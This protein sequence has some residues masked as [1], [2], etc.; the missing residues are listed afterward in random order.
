MF[1]GSPFPSPWLSRGAAVVIV[2]PDISCFAETFRSPI[3]VPVMVPT[4][5]CLLCRVIRVTLAAGPSGVV[6]P[7][8]PEAAVVC[9][10]LP[11]GF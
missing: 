1:V 6:A 10:G 3:A 9:I 2:V 4:K 7:D 11:G 8:C 5:G